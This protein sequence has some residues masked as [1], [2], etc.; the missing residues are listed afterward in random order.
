LVPVQIITTESGEE[1]VI[2]TR[3]EYDRLL[4]RLGDDEAEDRVLA[5]AARLVLDRIQSGEEAL[6]PP[7]NKS[8]SSPA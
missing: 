1:L 6:V 5:E 2:L 8:K 4:A 3:R 7:P